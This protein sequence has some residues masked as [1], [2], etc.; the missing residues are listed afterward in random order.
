MWSRLILP[1]LYHDNGA[2]WRFHCAGNILYT[3]LLLMVPICSHA[4]EDNYSQNL[5]AV[6]TNKIDHV[7]N[8]ETTAGFPA[9]IGYTV[10]TQLAWSPLTG[11]GVGGWPR[12]RLPS[13]P[14]SLQE[15]QALAEEAEVTL[16]ERWMRGNLD[17]VS[18]RDLCC[19]ACFEREHLFLPAPE[20]CAGCENVLE[21]FPR[22]TCWGLQNQVAYLRPKTKYPRFPSIHWF[23]SIPWNQKTHL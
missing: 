14:Q 9:I 12:Q 11:Q 1:T 13:R 18:L 8:G 23:A 22:R 6:S 5:F 16:T 4:K 15:E 21:K 7:W 19:P 17:V 10:L 2:P 20:T 3:K